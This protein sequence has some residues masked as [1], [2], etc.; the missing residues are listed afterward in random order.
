MKEGTYRIVIKRTIKKNQEQFFIPRNPTTQIKWT[1][2]LKKTNCLNSLQKNNFISLQVIKKLN[3]Q[4]KAYL[5]RKL[6]PQKVS[7]PN[8]A[9]HLKRTTTKY[10]QSLSEN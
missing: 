1:G 3:L 2:Y 7:L 4:F 6:Q 9:K 8:F 5:H 10:T